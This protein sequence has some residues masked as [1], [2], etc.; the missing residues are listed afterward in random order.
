MIIKN[1]FLIHLYIN[2][3]NKKVFRMGPLWG[4][5]LTTENKLN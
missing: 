4:N 1:I 2:T 5:A 3:L